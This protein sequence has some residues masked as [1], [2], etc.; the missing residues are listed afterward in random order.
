M[1]LK[2]ANEIQPTMVF[3]PGLM[4]GEEIEYRGLTQRQVAKDMG[5]S[6]TVLNEIIAGKRNI[7]TTTAFKIESALGIN[8]L[9]FMRM[10]TDYDYYTLKK[11][12]RKRAA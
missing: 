7:T 10:Q 1:K 3:H 4:L 11:E 12:M 2:T 9:I 5:V 8:A 6:A